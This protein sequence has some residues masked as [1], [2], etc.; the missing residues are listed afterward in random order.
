MAS[1][2]SALA[3]GFQEG[4][5]VT[6]VLPWED[7]L[8]GERFAAASEREL[9]WQP[10]PAWERALVSG[11][12]RAERS[13]SEHFLLGHSPWEP[14]WVYSPREVGWR[15]EQSPVAL[16]WERVSRQRGFRLDAARF[17]GE[18]SVWQ[19]SRGAPVRFDWPQEPGGWPASVQAGSPRA[20]FLLASGLDDWQPVEIL[21]PWAPVDSPQ[22]E[23][24]RACPPHPG[25]PRAPERALPW[26]TWLERDT[27]LPRLW[28]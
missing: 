8:S 11:W 7:S 4:T 1:A 16:A 27:G 3:F 22:D 26:V 28:R 18:R 6:Y 9:A 23:F 2:Q 5:A 17:P 24:P 19:R 21:Q 20:D 14:D 15:D 25:W 12:P 10:E 13:L